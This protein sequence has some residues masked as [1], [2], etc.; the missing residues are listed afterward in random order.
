MNQLDLDGRGLPFI[1]ALITEESELG[2]Q[3]K[4]FGG[5]HRE[6]PLS[7]IQTTSN[8]NQS[9]KSPGAV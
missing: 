5:G 7:R 1:C 8:G 4:T 2:T 9:D 3:N 6:R